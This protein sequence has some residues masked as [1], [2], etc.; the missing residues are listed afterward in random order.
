MGGR[1][2]K[3]FRITIILTLLLSQELEASVTESSKRCLTL[4]ASPR[5][6]STLEPFSSDGW[7]I[8]SRGRGV[9]KLGT[10][11]SCFWTSTLLAVLSSLQPPKR[12]NFLSEKRARPCDDFFFSCSVGDVN[13]KLSTE[14][15]RERRG[16]GSGQGAGLELTPLGDWFTKSPRNLGLQDEARSRFSFSRV[17]G[18]ED[19][20]RPTDRLRVN[21]GHDM[22]SAGTGGGLGAWR[23]WARAVSRAATSCCCW[24][25]FSV[26]S[27]ST[28]DTCNTNT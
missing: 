13:D 14:R 21:R 10:T 24:G 4:L 20:T 16:A 19:F 26:T 28:A 9:G 18:E 22:S 11:S 2:G 15:E 25:N 12:R 17:T 8:S 27:H 23:L 1:G 5:R 7:I 6:T 3:N